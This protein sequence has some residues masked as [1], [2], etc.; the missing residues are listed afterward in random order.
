MRVV[1]DDYEFSLVDDFWP[2]DRK[3][4]GNKG[5]PGGVKVT[6][7]NTGGRNYFIQELLVVEPPIDDRRKAA[8]SM[9]EIR[10]YAYSQVAL[11]YRWCKNVEI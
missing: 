1:R 5:T 2:E 3:G 4:N 8:T 7:P 6:T 11:K 9:E 10:V